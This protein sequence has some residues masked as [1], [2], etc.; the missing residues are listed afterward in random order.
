MVP[1]LQCSSICPG[2][3]I[4]RLTAGTGGEK[5]LNTLSDVSLAN[6]PHY[7]VD[8]ILRG[9]R[10][11]GFFCIA[12]LPL[13]IMNALNPSARFIQ[14][15]QFSD[16]FSAVGILCQF[17]KFLDGE[18][19][20][21][22]IDAVVFTPLLATHHARA[23]KGV[24]PVEQVFGWHWLVEVGEA[25]FEHIQPLLDRSRFHVFLLG[26]TL[27]IV[28]S[29]PMCKAVADADNVA[30][31]PCHVGLQDAPLGNVPLYVVDSRWHSVNVVDVIVAD[32]LDR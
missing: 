20:S 25:V 9:T 30:R 23:G 28:D 32:F 31:F 8:A 12:M 14:S 17:D 6:D 24:V 1:V 11:T 29:F 15:N 26:I 7:D 2:L 22:Y 13:N 19:V 4:Q 16:C 18:S 3:P 5:C 10:P 21:I 27:G